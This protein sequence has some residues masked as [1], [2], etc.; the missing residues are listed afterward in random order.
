MKPAAILLLAAALHAQS[1]ALT[2]SE[3]DALI[4][5]LR[6][7]ALRYRGQLPNFVVD[8]K[9]SRREDTSGSGKKWKQKDGYEEEVTFSGNSPRP[10]FRLLSVN[11][12]PATA[13]TQRPAGGIDPGMLAQAIVPT[14]IFG[15]R[16]EMAL[17]WQRWETHGDDRMMVLSFKVPQVVELQ[18]G[19]H[20]AKIGFHGTLWVNE[21]D[22][23]LA[24]I[25][26]TADLPHDDDIDYWAWKIDY[27][28]VNI[29]DKDLLVPMQL[30]LESR[31]GRQ[32]YENT[33]TF[34]NYRRFTATS[35]V[36]TEQPE[37]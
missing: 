7:S 25:E 22:L 19:N 16:S 29:G 27:A 17:A 8:Q 37:R 1:P 24:R 4:P 6:N 31:N 3:I 9:T 13:Q 30:L 18:R 21:A 35:N 34:S 15:P 33:E 28:T 12:K 14:W 10:T 2:Q 26:C 5:R 36:L 20:V 11:G 23:S 32:W